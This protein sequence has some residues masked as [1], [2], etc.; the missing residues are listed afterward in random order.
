MVVPFQAKLRLQV[1]MTVHG[2][3]KAV[4]E[5][6]FRVYTGHG[7]DFARTFTDGSFT[8]TSEYGL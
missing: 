7:G 5:P 1:S 8:S 2:M 6:I 4:M 3:V